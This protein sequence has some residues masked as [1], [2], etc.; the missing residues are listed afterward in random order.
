ML[1]VTPNSAVFGIP[2]V[3]RLPAVLRGLT[4]TPVTRPLLGVTV[5]MPSG[6]W[7]ND[8][9]DAQYTAE[10]VQHSEKVAQARVHVE[11]AIGYIKKFAILDSKRPI[12]KDLFPHLS[13]IVYVCAMQHG[14]QWVQ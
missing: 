6:M 1:N 5:N 2:P 10:Q 13:K 3:F 4:V 8:R 12:I 7:G 11:R 9:K 14:W